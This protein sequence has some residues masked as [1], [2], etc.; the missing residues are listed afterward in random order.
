MRAAAALAALALL[1][2][3]PGRANA[4]DDDAAAA[5]AAAD[6]TPPPPPLPQPSGGGGGDDDDESLG[7]YKYW[8]REASYKE[9]D[10]GEFDRKNDPRLK[11]VGGVQDGVLV[12]KFQWYQ[13]K[14][15]IWVTFHLKN[16]ENQTVSHDDNWLNFTA[17]GDVM[18]VVQSHHFKQESQDQLSKKAV[19]AVQ[20][21]FKY[22][23]VANRTKEQINAGWKTFVLRKAAKGKEWKH[24]MKEPANTGYVK[25]MRKDW[26]KYGSESDDPEFLVEKAKNIDTVIEA[27]GITVIQFVPS[28][29]DKAKEWS[30]QYGGAADAL[31]GDAVLV[32]VN[33]LTDTALME[34]YGIQITQRDENPRPQYVV[35]VDG[36]RLEPGYSGDTDTSKLVEFVRRLVKPPVVPLSTASDVTEL[37]KSHSRCAVAWGVP[38]ES[39]NFA[40][41]VKAA[42]ALQAVGEPTVSWAAVT[43]GDVTSTDDSSAAAY[44]RNAVPALKAGLVGPAIVLVGGAATGDPAAGQI[45]DSRLVASGGDF[46]APSLASTAAAWGF[47]VEPLADQQGSIA[48]TMQSKVD[49][50]ARLG[51]ATV[52]LHIK[53]KSTKTESG[54]CPTCPAAVE[55]V[56]SAIVQAQAEAEAEAVS[57]LLAVRGVV[58]SGGHIKG[59]VPQALA[60]SQGLDGTTFPGL[61]VLSGPTGSQMTY[62]YSAADRGEM[63]AATVTTFL[64]QVLSGEAVTSVRSETVPSPEQDKGAG[65]GVVDKV[66]GLNVQEFVGDDTVDTVLVIYKEGDDLGRK[67][68]DKAVKLADKLAHV[69]TVSFGSFDMDKNGL[70]ESLTTSDQLGDDAKTWD[71]IWLFPAGNAKPLRAKRKAALKDLAK[72]IKTKAAK[73]FDAKAQGLPTGSFTD[74]CKGCRLE[75]AEGA[76]G[77]L[78]V[79]ASCSGGAGSGKVSVE[80]STCEA[81]FANEDGDLV[82]DK[83]AAMA[84]E[85]EA[86]VGGT[87]GEGADDGKEL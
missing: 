61:T 79:C 13:D 42:R 7:D 35:L 69:P 46:T 47:Q 8:R 2:A 28:W 30:K 22:K 82:C 68:K 48:A 14:R 25:H 63:S 15:Q 16:V 52:F 40:A 29:S 86:A 6:S 20:L 53:E 54:L 51:I 19:Y 21:P 39:P 26:K 44:L 50:G 58:S 49:N 9:I 85:V 74:S 18:R 78:L 45:T 24:L 73:A 62:S 36:E 72:W 10:E 41:V 67:Y 56:A 37:L 83:A 70:P 76:G 27:G 5:E 80:L 33:A 1:A 87:E 77:K 31:E 60:T 81:G 32:K 64:Q 84:A 43:V 17:T 57:P 66:V 3:A 38:E 12:P 23:V 34:R 55:A 59:S 11:G 71:G 4:D 65:S 75:E